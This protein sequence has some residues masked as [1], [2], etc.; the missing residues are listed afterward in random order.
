MKELQNQLPSKSGTEG[1]TKVPSNKGIILVKNL[2]FTFVFYFVFAIPGIIFNFVLIPPL[3]LLT[4]IFPKVRYV[5]MWIARTFFRFLIGSLSLVRAI[6]I[7]ELNGLDRIDINAPAVYVANH[8]T[9]IDVLILMAL[10]PRANCL[11]KARSQPKGKGARKSFLP[12]FWKPFINGPFSLLGY[13]PMPND[14][15]DRNALLETFGRCVETLQRGRS[16]VVFPEGTRSKTCKLLPFI[17]FPFKLAIEAKVP[18]QPVVIHNQTSFM[19]KGSV[20]I[21]SSERT[22]FRL[23]F[24]KPISPITGD[25][26]KDL[27]YHS[28]RKMRKILDDCNSKYGYRE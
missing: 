9:L 28:R 10:I 14:W 5:S 25:R 7:K 4:K 15:S 22:D 11:V 12:G 20:T 6:K 27:S 16:L 17:D 19:P 13:I 1:L 26:A 3:W 8:R 21:R 24:L 2:F 23:S 18:V